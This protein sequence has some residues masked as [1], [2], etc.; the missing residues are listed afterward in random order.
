MT[1]RPPRPNR[2][3]P[4]PPP[5]D[6]TPLRAHYLKKS[7]ITLQLRKELD[8]LTAAP[9]LAHLGPP[10]AP[11][12]SP[13]LDLPLLKYIF[14]HFVLSFP[15]M[16]AAPNNFYSDKLQPFV[17]SLFAR[18]LSSA[19]LDDPDPQDPAPRK[20]IAKL[21]RNFAMFFSSAI[22]LDEPEDILRLSQSDLQSLERAVDKRIAKYSPRNDH[23][24]V[25]IVSVRTVTEKGR[26]R[27]RVH[28]VCI[29]LSSLVQLEPFLGVSHPHDPLRETGLRFT[30]LRRFQDA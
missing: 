18:N 7:L 1:T 26:V 3:L 12:S 27:S 8:D 25:N 9:T 16:A 21:E 24:H 14:R 5:T 29:L 4:P 11:T 17:D 6:L 23:F 22:K 10:F 2:P 20:I 19:L 13:R 15:F 28:E 30:P